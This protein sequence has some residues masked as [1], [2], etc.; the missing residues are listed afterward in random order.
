MRFPWAASGAAALHGAD[1]SIMLAAPPLRP[2]SDVG[3]AHEQ[4]AESRIVLLLVDFINPLQFAGADRLATE[5]VAAARAALRLKHALMRERFSTVYANDNYGIWQSEFSDV[6]RRCTG[7]QGPPGEIARMLAP[8]GPELT[9]LK[10][11]HSAFYGTPLDLLLTQLHAQELILTG[12]T[13]DICVQ[14]TA[15]DAYIRGYRIRVPANCTAAESP[16]RKEAALDYM[17]R[18]LKCDTA[19][20]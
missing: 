4:L 19:P 11:R 20:L 6:L 16:E 17:G 18:V 5:A 13:A 12:L 3:T 14:L 1:A 10:P 7:M 8:E 9:I 15:M 2:R